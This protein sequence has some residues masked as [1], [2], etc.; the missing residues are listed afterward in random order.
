MGCILHK[1][2]CWDRH[3]AFRQSKAD[4]ALWHL[5]GHVLRPTDGPLPDASWQSDGLGRLVMST[6][7][8]IVRVYPGRNVEIDGLPEGG[9]FAGP[10]TLT[11]NPDQPE[12]VTGLSVSFAGSTFDLEEPW[13]LTVEPKQYGE[14][15]YPLLVEVQ[16]SDV[17]TPSQVSIPLSIILPTWEDDIQ[18]LAD[19]A[20]GSCHGEKAALEIKL[21]TPDQW[22]GLFETIM[23]VVTPTEEGPALMPPGEP[24]GE[25][26]VELLKFWQEAGFMESQEP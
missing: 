22:K 14:G 1:S 26:A 5:Q 21:Y 15:D 17:S 12:L 2:L 25:D 16:Y 6:D 24:I 23:I 10:L 7:A 13:E 3:I 18:L 4:D 8:G 9:V 19:S 20:C 11:F